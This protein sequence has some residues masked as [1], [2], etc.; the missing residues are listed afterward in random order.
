MD[1][2][3]QLGQTLGDRY[4]LKKI[5]GQG[6]YYQTYWAEDREQ[7]SEPCVLRLWLPPNSE[8]THEGFKGIKQQ[9]EQLFSRQ[10]YQW[11]TLRQV[12]PLTLLG[13]PTLATVEDYIEGASYREL[14]TL[15]QSQGKLFIPT[16][17]DQLFQQI[18]P[19][20]AYFHAQGIAHG[21][22]TLDHLIL[23]KRDRAPV[24]VGGGFFWD[25]IDKLQEQKTEIFVRTKTDLQQLAAMLWELYTG[26]S[27]LPGEPAKQPSSLKYKLDSLSSPLASLLSP[28][29]TQQTEL[30]TA[31][32]LLQQISLSNSQAALL[33][34]NNPNNNNPHNNNYHHTV[35]PAPS[36]ISSPQV[37]LR[38]KSQSVPPTPPSINPSP[39]SLSRRSPL[40]LYGCLGKI[41]L[42]LALMLGSG[43]VGWFGGKLWIQQ[44]LQVS[45][46]SDILQ[47]SDQPLSQTSPQTPNPETKIS[48]EEL[49]R[50]TTLRTRQQ[51][52]GIDRRYFKSLVDQMVAHP[53]SNSPDPQASNASN[54]S[55]TS[56][57]WDHTAAEILDKLALLSPDALAQLGQYDREGRDR[58][59]Q[60]VNQLNLSSRSLL[61]LVNAQFLSLF[62]N[63]EAQSFE[64]TPVEQVWD[65]LIKD[66]LKNLQAGNNYERLT[67][68]EGSDR[69]ETNGTLEPGQGK[70]MVIRLPAQNQM[71]LSLQAN[72]ETQLSVYTPTGKTPILED[73]RQKEW[74][75]TLPE[76]GFYEIILVSKASTPVAYQLQL[77]TQPEAI[78]APTE[79]LQSN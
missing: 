14:L 79:P 32:F 40:P 47:S 55:D 7:S 21:H 62:P 12:L 30:P 41:A 1:R 6:K 33:N 56:A 18:I 31:E 23:Q 61:D 64:N 58:Q 22:L 28:W 44:L 45:E 17:L 49:Q 36:P 69:L 26:Q 27:S 43:T 66:T 77:T 19:V 37:T 65:A 70:A 20:L 16:E 63:L 4:L 15:R 9:A 76:T 48:A 38:T 73:S 72:G 29:L 59:K 68:T 13:Q 35:T 78:P 67:L 25:A 75:G 34:H 60:S 54:P 74:S 53:S 46:K 71:T 24:L 3:L 51:T 2:L 11:A 39:M 42:V 5:L 10:H 57:R 50:K 52:L 8:P